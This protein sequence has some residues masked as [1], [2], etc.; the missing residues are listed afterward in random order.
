MLQR[1]GKQIAFVLAVLV[2]STVI[3]WQLSLDVSYVMIDGT[4]YHVTS[5]NQ[6]EEQLVRGLSD[7][8]H[9]D[10]GSVAVFVF[11]YE[12]DWGI[13]MKD[14]QYDIDILWVDSGG[15]VVHT[16]SGAKP[17]SYPSTIFRPQNKHARYVIEMTSGTIERTGIHKG[18]KVGKLSG[19]IK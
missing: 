7:T 5:I 16:V 4:R 15:T 8:K 9:L 17:S 14:M 19:D 3:W 12:S 1:W 10:P 18:S 11:P 2:G 6:T 13:W